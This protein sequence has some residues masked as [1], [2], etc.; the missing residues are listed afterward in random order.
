MSVVRWLTALVMAAQ[1]AVYAG[2]NG[3]TNIG[4]IGG[5]YWEIVV[6]PYD[7]NI[8]YTTTGAGLFKSEDGGASWKNAGLN[9]LA[10]YG[11]TMD[12][13][14][15]DILFA[16]AT[17]GRRDDASVIHMFKSTD[18][19]ASWNESDA[20][21]S[22]CCISLAIDPQNT[23][24]LYVL[25]TNPS[26]GIFRSTDAGA[27]WQRVYALS[28]DLYFDDLVTDANTPGVLYAGARFV[29]G[30]S[31]IFK[32]VDGGASWNEADTGL[33]DLFGPVH[34]P[35]HLTV[36]PRGPTI[37]ATI[38]GSLLVRTTDGAETWHAVGPL[39][40]EN[41]NNQSIAAM[42]IDPRDSNTL[43]IPRAQSLQ[44]SVI[45]KSTDGGASWTPST[46]VPDMQWTLFSSRAITLD[47]ETP[48]RCTPPRRAACTGAS[49]GAQVLRCIPGRE[50]F[51]WPQSRPIHSAR[52][53][54]WPD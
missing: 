54:Y 12:P 21:L 16:V 11:L 8:F 47:P 7:P 42:V 50:R 33:E 20:G 48:A 6:D 4:P 39:P 28:E 22:G 10:V 38:T 2:E 13:Q 26:R 30:N 29:S 19:G 44:L 46:P 41:R 51:P 52:A 45:F 25:S 27:T 14:D 53:I 9:G 18:A 3:W 32:S 23:D 5:T 24:T 1:G 43:Y 35:I 40:I 36:D 17:N 37:Y 31:A 15:P 34:L 49:M